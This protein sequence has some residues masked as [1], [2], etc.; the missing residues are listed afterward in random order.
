MS[1]AIAIALMLA[2]SLDDAIT[3]AIT[4]S[5]ELR[6]LE[7]SV[8]EARAN[9]SLNNAFRPAASIGTTPGYATGL[10]TAVL[11]QVPAIATIEAH[12]LFY[13]RSA[14]AERLTM[15]SEVDAAMARLESRKRD[16]AMNVA[17]LYSRAAAD[18]KLIA[19][20]DRRVTAYETIASRTDA[21]R[22]EGRARDI[23]VDRAALQLAGA[24][25]TA[26]LARNR[27]ELDQ[28][29]LNQLVGENVEPGDPWPPT[30]LRM[31]EHDPELKS[32]DSR[33]EAL[34]RAVSLE[35]RFF[36]PS[37]AAQIQYSRLFDRFRRYYLNFRPDDLSLG[38]TIT[39]PLSPNRAAA[40]ARRNAQLQQLI[41]LRDARRMEMDLTS[42]EAET[43]VVQAAAESEMA[44]RA[45]AIAQEGLRLAHDLARE[46]RGEAN[47]VPLAQIA[48]SDA[49]E[50]L[51]NATA[52]LA[53]AKARVLFLPH[54]SYNPRDRGVF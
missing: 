44:S 34:Q 42:R 16:V 30:R 19:S 2:I 4:R 31:T 20:A 26:L 18:S 23:D 53:T 28:L 50:E 54:A 48:L 40:S 32:L 11:G 5:P 22:R 10:P 3:R 36:Q 25:R 41:A 38:A 8:A 29:R 14:Q 33:I 49:E 47:D 12:R 6:V 51:A 9:A 13:D 46:G 21:L 27:L 39:I 52:L 43:D 1:N 24:K 37:I 35:E 15:M 17:E 45:V 7:A